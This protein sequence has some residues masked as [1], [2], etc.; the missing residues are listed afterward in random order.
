MGLATVL[1]LAPRGFFI[2]H[3]HAADVV[4]AGE[5]QDYAAL[6]PGITNG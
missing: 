1:G 2:P 6:V 3:R 5:R 4:P